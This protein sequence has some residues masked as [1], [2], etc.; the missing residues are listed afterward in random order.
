MMNHYWNTLHIEVGFIVDD[1]TA[2]EIE[3]YKVDNS[4][5]AADKLTDD[6]VT[7]QLTLC[8]LEVAIDRRL[9]LGGTI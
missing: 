1:P 4:T 7:Q 5:L 2:E 9:R 8:D 3:T 6:V